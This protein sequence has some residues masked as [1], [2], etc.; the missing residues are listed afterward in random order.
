MKN[1]V[2]VI[3]LIFIFLQSCSN[4]SNID[5]RCIGVGYTLNS[6]REYYSKNTSY[7]IKCGAYADDE[8]GEIVSVECEPECEIPKWTYYFNK[9]SISNL[10]NKYCIKSS[11][12]VYSKSELNE[13]TKFC[14]KIA[15]RKIENKYIPHDDES[16]IDKS[17][18]S[19]TKWETNKYIITY[20]QF[21]NELRK[22]AP[23]FGRGKFEFEP[24]NQHNY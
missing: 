1:L 16:M 4:E 5:E 6:I 15:Y 20:R 7:D 13:Y 17:T 12:Y 22:D 19:I 11:M 10:E 23:I 8:T 21:D 24:N 9:E 2:S 14:N 3:S 18:I